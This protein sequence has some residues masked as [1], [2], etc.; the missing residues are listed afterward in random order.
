MTPEEIRILHDRVNLI[1]KENRA[2]KRA[3]MTPEEANEFQDAINANARRNRSLQRTERFRQAVIERTAE[4]G[5]VTFPISSL[6][7]KSQFHLPTKFLA[8]ADASTFMGN[9]AVTMLHHLSFVS[10][11][12]LQVTN[13][14]R[15]LIPRESVSEQKRIDCIPH[16]RGK[17]DKVD[18]YYGIWACPDIVRTISFFFSHHKRYYK[19]EEGFIFFDYIIAKSNDP[20]K[21]DFEIFTQFKMGNGGTVKM[22]HE[23]LCRSSQSIQPDMCIKIVC[24]KPEG[25][26]TSLQN[27]PT[28]TIVHRNRDMET[29]VSIALD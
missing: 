11:K 6:T 20:N 15:L 1:N 26:R 16:L 8:R 12:N 28:W 19:A 29:E 2:K 23:L 21:H 7:R 5:P 14:N 9:P 24:G 10:A 18:K 4:T 3:K 22:Y 25:G 27:A 13:S 17:K